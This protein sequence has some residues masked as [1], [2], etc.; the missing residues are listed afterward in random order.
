MIDL[1]TRV[2]GWLG[3][4]LLV[5]AALSLVLVP[6]SWRMFHIML[7]RIAETI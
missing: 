3:G 7:P 4:L 1:P 5:A 6:L 2:A